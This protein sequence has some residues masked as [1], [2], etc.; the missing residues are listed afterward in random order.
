MKLSL[1]ELWNL[2]F[3]KG[4]QQH[5][6]WT[7]LE[8]HSCSEGTGGLGRSEDGGRTAS[9]VT[10]LQKL[11]LALSAAPKEKL[12]EKEDGGKISFS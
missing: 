1:I 5:V 4:T 9:A 10:S 12:P 3:A 7:E 2:D 8:N 6:V 11:P